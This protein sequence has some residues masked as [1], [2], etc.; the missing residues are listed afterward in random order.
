MGDRVTG[1]LT[2]KGVLRAADVAAVAEALRD[3][4]A[5]PMEVSGRISDALR[6]NHAAFIV[7]DVNFGD[8]QDVTKE[9]LAAAGL[10]WIWCHEEGGG[11]G[12]RVVYKKPG[13]DEQ[14]YA[15]S[16]T[17]GKI[18]I[19]LPDFMDSDTCHNALDIWLWGDETGFSVMA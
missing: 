17:T 3:E 13:E 1:V 8:L 6:G 12:S 9:T 19:S 11:F 4:C 16:R 15:S 2:L 10:G 7:H 5:E 18:F 14:E